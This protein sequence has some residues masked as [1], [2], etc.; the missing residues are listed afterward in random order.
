MPVRCCF[1]YCLK[2]RLYLG[3]N[4]PSSYSTDFCSGGKGGTPEETIMQV[5]KA[6]GIAGDELMFTATS[7]YVTQCPSTLPFPFVFLDTYKTDL[8]AASS[9]LASLETTIRQN[10]VQS[11]VAACGTQAEG[12]DSLVSTMNSDLKALA[13]KVDET[14]A[15]LACDTV[16]PT[17]TNTAYVTACNTSVHS[18]YYGYCCKFM[19]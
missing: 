18:L 4:E 11:I 7:F 8:S 19:W 12:I 15:A 16:V 9:A 10:T 2:L 14:L 3:S 5:L 17:F 1:L 13:T 6:R